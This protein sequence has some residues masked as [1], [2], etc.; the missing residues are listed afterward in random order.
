M[1][2]CV[3]SSQV[4]AC[5]PVGYAGLETIAWH[6]AKGLAA[7]GHQVALVA[8]E[9]SYCPGAEIIPTGPPGAWPEQIA[10]GG[11]GK[12]WPGYWKHLLAFDAIIDHSWSKFSYI[13]K[14]EGR[15]LAPV[16][17]VCHAPINTMYQQLPPV[18]KPCMVC[19]SQDQAS[20]LQ[21]L[22]N[23]QARVAYNGVDIDTYAPIDIPRSDRFL[24]LARFS[25]IKGPDLAI[26]ACKE[27][28]VGL[29]LIGDTTITNEPEL[30]AKCKAMADGKQIRIIGNQ[31]RNACVWWY[32]Q[33]HTLLHP[34]ARFREPFGL[35]PVEAQL[36]GCPVIAWDNGA[37][38]ET[39]KHQ[40]TGWLVRS[41]VELVQAISQVAKT[42][43]EATQVFRQ[44]CR[45]WAKQFS[46][47][48][49]VQR[50]ETLCREA[51]DTGG[52]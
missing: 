34:N 43:G 47:E 50:Y 40:E 8:P 19:I 16:L 42:R 33:A 27:A 23:T 12:D 41:Q 17:G 44:K 36:C 7:K 37:M 30:L 24:F 10:Y 51:I 38:R 32:S 46:I 35:A 15:L 2:I 52:W 14:M 22:F 48:A 45:E 28:G 4:F 26:E 5:P 6:I 29:D 39:I 49:M 9:G 20:H 3:I 31:S 13:L 11:N 25:S 18:P 21:A 1:R